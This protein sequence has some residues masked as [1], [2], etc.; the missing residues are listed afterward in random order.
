MATHTS[1]GHSSTPFKPVPGKRHGQPEWAGHSHLPFGER[2]KERHWE[3]FEE[4]QPPKHCK[5]CPPPDRKREDCMIRRIFTAGK[6]SPQKRRP[7]FFMRQGSPCCRI[8][9]GKLAFVEIAK[10]NPYTFSCVGILRL[11]PRR[12]S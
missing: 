8:R 3:P 7:F 2:R 11:L 9:S 12:R 6:G 5:L 4:N 10:K 1:T